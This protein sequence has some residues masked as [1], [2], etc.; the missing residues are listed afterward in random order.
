MAKDKHLQK[1]IAQ[2]SAIDPV[3]ALDLEALTACLARSIAREE[4]ARRRRSQRADAAEQD[5]AGV[6]VRSADAARQLVR[7]LAV[8]DRRPGRA[9]RR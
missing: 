5:R 3:V 7:R 4:A 8:A 2:I 6:G 1:V 9:C